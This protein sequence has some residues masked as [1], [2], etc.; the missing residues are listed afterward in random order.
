MDNFYFKLGQQVG[1]EIDDFEH[2]IIEQIDDAIKSAKQMCQNTEILIDVST[3]EFF[4][5]L[6]AGQSEITYKLPE[7]CFNKQD[8][9]AFRSLF[10]LFNEIVQAFID[11]NGKTIDIIEY[12]CLFAK[13]KFNEQRID[14]T[15]SAGSVKGKKGFVD[16]DE[17]KDPNRINNLGAFLAHIDATYVQLP[18]IA[19]TFGKRDG[20]KAIVATPTF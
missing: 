5:E 14:W 2:Q 1:K 3:G 7:L 12:P 6:I 18:V 4:L 20:L 8:K 15:F 17:F 13:I 16:W 9:L 19:R 11:D 10:G